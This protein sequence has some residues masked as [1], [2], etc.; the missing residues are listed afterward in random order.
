MAEDEA[1]EEE[2]GPSVELGEGASVEGAPL[3]RVAS[4]LTW[5]IERSEVDRKEGDTTIRTADGPRELS[6]VLEEVDV[7]YFAT[8][9]EFVG[10]VR[11]VVGV[12]PVPTE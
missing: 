12:G 8:R 10:A 5:P 4:R 6:A 7:T 3:A 1:D 2:A 11:D 9:Q